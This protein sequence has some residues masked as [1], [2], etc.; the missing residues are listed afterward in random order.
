M[1]QI[2]FEQEDEMWVAYAPDGTVLGS[3]RLTLVYE[4]AEARQNFMAAMREGMTAV[5][6][7]NNLT[8]K[9]V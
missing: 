4:S 5:L 8:V 1:A 7:R 2:K 9:W 3:I 6:K